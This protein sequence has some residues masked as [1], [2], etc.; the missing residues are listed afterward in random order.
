M[1]TGARSHIRISAPGKVHRDNAEY[2]HVP[3]MEQNISF[4][5]AQA[6][7]PRRV[8][9]RNILRLVCDNLKPSSVVGSRPSRPGGCYPPS[10]PGFLVTTS[11]FQQQARFFGF[12]TVRHGF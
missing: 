10:I 7:R 2:G 3:S 5:R 8:T 4:S 9:R 11:W 1:R 6:V 12:A